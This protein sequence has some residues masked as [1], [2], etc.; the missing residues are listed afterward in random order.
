MYVFNSLLDFFPGMLEVVSDE[1][2]ERFQCL[3]H[4]KTASGSAGLLLA[5]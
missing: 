1:H 2:G 4:R 3:H 5:T